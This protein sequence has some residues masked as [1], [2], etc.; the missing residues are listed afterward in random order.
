MNAPFTPRADELRRLDAM[1]AQGDEILNR[2]QRIVDR[3]YP[4]IGYSAA[5]SYPSRESI[6]HAFAV[7][8]PRSR[9]RRLAYRAILPRIRAKVLASRGAA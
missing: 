3:L 4:A 1:I 9:E 2:T 8:F 7:A 6:H 5:P